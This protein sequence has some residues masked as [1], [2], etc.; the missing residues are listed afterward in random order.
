MYNS[1]LCFQSLKE[2]TQ[3]FRLSKKVLEF[4][5]TVL[6]G[7]TFNAQFATPQDLS[8]WLTSLVVLAKF[9]DHLKSKRVGLQLGAH[10]LPFS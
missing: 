8:I 5:F 1:R 2:T 7:T 9:P 10:Y 3:I 4:T 6:D